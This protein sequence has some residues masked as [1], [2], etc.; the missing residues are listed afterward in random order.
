MGVFLE[1]PEVVD[2]AWREHFK[3]GLQA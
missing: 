3:E 2:D 1:L